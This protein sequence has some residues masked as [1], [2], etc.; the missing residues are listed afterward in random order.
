M[1]DGGARSGSRAWFSATGSR[2]PGDRHRARYRRQSAGD[3]QRLLASEE[4]RR[5]RIRQ[6]VTSRFGFEEMARECLGRYWNQRSPAER[7]EFI[8]LF[9]DLL[10]RTYINDIEAYHE[11]QQIQYGAERIEGDQV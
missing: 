7:A 5:M 2:R 10:E 8:K 11:G 4:Q 6:V 3:R 9:T 1:G